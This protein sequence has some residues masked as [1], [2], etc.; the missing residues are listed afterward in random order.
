[1]QNKKS[2]KIIS[3]IITFLAITSIIAAIIIKNNIDKKIAET[4][5]EEK[6]IEKDINY[7]KEITIK[8]FIDNFNI[9]LQNRKLKYLLNNEYMKTDNNTYYYGIFDDIG[10]YVVPVNYTGNQ[11]KDIV[12][13]TSIFYPSKSK[14]KEL[15]YNY[16][17]T[18]L[19]VNL[20]TISEDD[21]KTL[22][23]KAE[24]H[25]KSNKALDENNGIFISYN[26]KE[27]NIFY[28]I[29]KNYK[30]NGE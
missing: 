4:N 12:K 11:E 29:T 16:V 5:Q 28:I 10:F 6:V 15:A 3:Y 18:L 19:K 13:T 23:F 24:E 7:S 17:N 1:M 14:N 2:L 25:S 8:E 9:E 21:I 30:S 22:L 26:E 20:T 27:N